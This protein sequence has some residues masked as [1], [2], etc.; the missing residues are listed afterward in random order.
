MATLFTKIIRGELPSFKVYEDEHCFAFLDIRP[1]HGG[2]TLVVPKTEADH[3]TD[4]PEPYYSAVF[5]AAK[6]IALAIR[7]VS[8]APR[9]GSAIVGFEVPHFHVHLVPL[10]NPTDLNFSHAKA[11][12]PA[13]LKAM[14]DAILKAMG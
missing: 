9:V 6:K 2:H 8:G 14:Q 7:Q 10:W 1:I 13:E 12:S 5:K 3:F 4:L 11:A